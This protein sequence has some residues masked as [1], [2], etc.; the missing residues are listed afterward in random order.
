MKADYRQLKSLFDDWRGYGMKKSFISE[1][2]NRRSGNYEILCDKWRKIYLEMDHEELIQRFHLESDEEA[3]YVIYF[4]EKYRLDKKSGMLTLDS[5]P[6]RILSFNTV[7]SIYNLFYYSRPGAKIKGEFVPY[8]QV[9]RAAP[10]APA[11]QRTVVNPLAGKFNGRQELLEKACKAMGG[12][13]IR[14]GDVGYQ[15]NAFNC[16][17]VQV[18]F[19]DGDDEFEAQANILFDADITDF[20]HEESVCCIGSDLVRRLSEEAGLG[21]VDQLLGSMI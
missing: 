17:P 13:P 14:Q 7:M 4:H 11:F 15:L 20:L 21:D 3:M 19:W 5:D 2:G 12:V 1:G 9:K 8:R 10:F 16:I 6:D 18:L